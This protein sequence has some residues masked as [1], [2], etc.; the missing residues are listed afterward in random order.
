MIVFVLQGFLRYRTYDITGG[1]ANENTGAGLHG[2]LFVDQYLTC[3]PS[4]EGFSKCRHENAIA[5]EW[6]TRN[7][8]MRNLLFLY[9]VP[10]VTLEKLK[11]ILLVGK[12]G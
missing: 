8:L 11:K 9:H 5:I 1:G 6:S 12:E 7:L 2:Q 4:S 3:A 10:F